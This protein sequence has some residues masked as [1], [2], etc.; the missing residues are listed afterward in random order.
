MILKT[1]PIYPERV[2][3]YSEQYYKAHSNLDIAATY[4]LENGFDL[5]YWLGGKRKNKNLLSEKQIKKLDSIGMIWSKRSASKKSVGTGM[6]VNQQ[7][8]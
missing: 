8:Q 3:S 1:E 2:Y 7:T 4:K 5:G 6:E